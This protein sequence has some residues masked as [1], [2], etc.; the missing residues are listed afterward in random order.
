MRI[1]KRDN[2]LTEFRKE[3]IEEAVFKASLET[4][5]NLE[6][7]RKIAR[8]ITSQ[9]ASLISKRFKKKIPH[10]EDI[11]D[12][13]EEC[14]MKYGFT[15]I[16]KN[17]ILYRRRRTLLREEK[18]T[19]YG[20]EDDLKLSVN[21]IK[22]LERRYLLK[23]SNKQVVETPRQMFRRVAHY[24]AGAEK[25]FSQ[26]APYYEDKFFAIMSSLEFLP[27]SPTLMNAGTSLG[28]LSACFALPVKDSME[29]IF[30]ALKEMALIHQSGGGTGFNF[31]E[32]RPRG[33]IVFSTKGEASGPVS[34]I[35][36]FNA[37]T[38]TIVQGGKRRGANMAILSIYHPD[39]LEFIESKTNNELKNFNISVLVDSKFMQAVLK[40]RSISFI[41]PRTK[42][43]WGKIKARILFDSICNCA[44]KT[45]EPGMIFLESLNRDNPLEKLG[46]LE[47]TNPCA[48]LPLFP[49][50]SC[51]LGSINLSKIT[52][53][54]KINWGKL[55]KLVHLGIRFLDDVIEVN[56]FPLAHIKKI[57]LKTRKVGLGVM[58]FHDMLLKMGI[59]Y[60]TPQAEKLGRRIMRFIKTES[61]RASS[62]LAQ[63][64]GVFPLY[65]KS[66]YARR[67][68]KLRNATLNAIAPTG[69]IS[70]IASC[71]SG[72]EPVFSLV[73]I[74]RVL[75]GERLLEV[76]PVFEEVAKKNNFYIPEILYRLARTNS[77]K[78]IKGIPRYLK[79]LFK[80]ALEIS[81][82]W[83]LRIQKAFQDYVDNSVSKTVNLSFESTPQD[84]KKIY[85]W[86]YK[87]R[88]KGITV[89][90]Y[91]T[92]EAVYSLEDMEDIFCPQ[93]TCL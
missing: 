43:E 14:L 55:K 88:L 70:L 86:A 45:G 22:V 20:V 17:Y 83:H 5:Q 78:G 19:L 80:T 2:K 54:K 6:E 79:R 33:D 27:N 90:R 16:A 36:I 47:I 59:P 38:Q 31:S 4:T 49:Y 65:K 25:K 75:G 71:S 60:D 10:V 23:D 3:R 1:K 37:A 64:R 35:K 39:I 73:F 18:R 8:K 30:Q 15:D 28:Q 42:K 57:T 77:L 85:L 93:E 24:V 91:G 48:E 87:N 41:N 67:G 66:I 89:F 53:G 76:N 46:T 7:S 68:L 52:D 62:I 12:T 82:I 50:E 84:V 69:T 29:S 21:A 72:I 61:L 26:H 51:N 63:E 40:N 81:P 44:W 9:V 13:V 74:K 92:R 58:G 56:K 34:F 11:Q 32:L